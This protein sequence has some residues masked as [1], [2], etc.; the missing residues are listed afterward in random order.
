MVSEPPG[1]LAMM[2]G[3]ARECPA[4][5]VHRPLR[6]ESGSGRSAYTHAASLLDS[7]IPVSALNNDSDQATLS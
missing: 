6:Q 3:F 4:A 7:R 2:A 1:C 5:L